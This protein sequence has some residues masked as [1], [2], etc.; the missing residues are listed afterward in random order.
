[1]FAVPPLFAAL[2]AEDGLGGCMP[3]SRTTLLRL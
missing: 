2:L 1:M 3:Q